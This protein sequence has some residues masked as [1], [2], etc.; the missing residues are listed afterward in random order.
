MKDTF[1][2]LELLL[3]G[4]MVFSMTIVAKAGEGNSTALKNTVILIIRHAEKPDSGDGLSPMG[5]QRAQLYANYFKHFTV[6]SAPLKIDSI[7]AAADSAGSHR[8]R[9]TV[10]P[11]SRA[12]G[13]PINSSF[14][15][16]N[17]QKLADEIFSRPHGHAILISWHHEE[18]P[19]LVRALGANPNSLFPKA[20]WPGDVFGWVIQLRYDADGHLFDVKRINEH[21]LPDDSDK[22]ALK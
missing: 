3:C 11:T 14:K 21:L 2:K 17:F 22:H 8:P 9:L 5:E 12:L 7:F 15:D 20:K 16:K 1:K 18:I 10:E 13:I 4:L 6:D 19:Q